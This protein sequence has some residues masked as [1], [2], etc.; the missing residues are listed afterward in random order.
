MSWA[1]TRC[2]QQEGVMMPRSLWKGA[3]SFGLVNIGESLFQGV[4]G[5]SRAPDP[6]SF[7]C[8]HVETETEG[9]DLRRLFT[10]CQRGHGDCRLFDPGQDGGAGFGAAC[11]GGI[12]GR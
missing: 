5:S 4:G 11:V 9:K 10:E 1:E 7:Y 2:A 3:I 6:G 12:V 8:K